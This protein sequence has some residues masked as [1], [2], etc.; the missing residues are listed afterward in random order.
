MLNGAFP[1]ETTTASSVNFSLVHINKCAL[2]F[3]KGCG[4]AP[5]FNHEDLQCNLSLVHRVIMKAAYTFP[6]SPSAFNPVT[7]L[8]NGC[9][10]F[11][12]YVEPGRIEMCF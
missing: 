3:K 1:F 8:I 6:I 4:N 9:P 12:K 7:G 11:F 5:K 2:F 10:G